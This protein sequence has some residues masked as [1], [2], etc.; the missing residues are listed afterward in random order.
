[1]SRRSNR[2][3]RRG[4]TPPRIAPAE[5]KVREEIAKVLDPLPQESRERVITGLGN[6]LGDVARPSTRTDDDVSDLLHLSEAEHVGG[7]LF[8]DLAPEGDFLAVIERQTAET[9]SRVLMA[10]TGPR[11]VE[12]P[13]SQEQLTAALADWRDALVS[14]RD[15]MGNHL[16]KLDVVRE[17]RMR[18][19]QRLDA[20]LMDVELANSFLPRTPGE[21]RL[22][23]GRLRALALR[24]P[25]LQ[26][27][28]RASRLY[29]TR[30]VAR[31]MF[32]EVLANTAE[33]GAFEHEYVKELARL[34]VRDN[35]EI[36]KATGLDALVAEA[37][38]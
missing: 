28:A 26:A 29:F 14:E 21:V 8:N 19:A 34:I 7:S 36:A 18:K 2:G 1:M 9:I 38:R 20:L 35:P 11:P 31:T 16:D 10:L 30:E 33:W 27:A 22:T 3:R 24:E 6:A 23:N 4:P 32:D 12:L 37:D 25:T 5:R 15:N 17:S 13:A